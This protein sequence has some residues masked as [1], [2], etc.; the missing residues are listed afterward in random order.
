MVTHA[1]SLYQARCDTGREPPH[2]DWLLLAAAGTNGKD[3]PVGEVYGR[4]D[5]TIAYKRLDL[6]AHDGG[7]WRARKDDPGPLPGPGWA[8]SAVQ[9][10]AGKRGEPGERGPAGP[11]GARIARLTV[12]GYQLAVN[13]SDGSVTTVD[14]RAMFERYDDEVRR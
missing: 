14:L 9:G 13:L 3:A 12:D 1:G 8:L 4:Y 5:P 7:E 2:E 6:V 10:K 11:P